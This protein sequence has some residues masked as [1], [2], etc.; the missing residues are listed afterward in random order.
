MSDHAGNDLQTPVVLELRKRGNQVA[1]PAVDKQ[2]AAGDE[3]LKVH[4]G[5]LVEPVVVPGAFELRAG[6]VDGAFDKR[7]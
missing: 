4:P 6:Q 3:A 5:E 2:I 7:T 1:P